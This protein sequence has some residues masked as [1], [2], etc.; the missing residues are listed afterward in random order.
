[1]NQL[2]AF[3]NKI[4]LAAGL[5]RRVVVENPLRTEPVSRIF[6]LDRGQPVDRF[7]IERFLAKYRNHI[8]GN[9]LEV[10]EDIY[11]R[12]FA[13]HDLNPVFHIL[14]LKETKGEG[15]N[16]GDLTGF[17]ILP[18]EA[19]GES[20]TLRTDSTGFSTSHHEATGE[21][22]TLHGDLTNAATLPEAVFDCFICT[23]T[24]NF[25]YEIEKAVA[26]TCRLLKPGGTLLA[27]VAGISQISAYDRDRWGDYWRLTPQSAKK[28]FGEVFGESNVE[29]TVCGNFAAARALLDGL[30]VEDLPDPE[31]L[32][33]HDADYPVIIGI[34]A[35]RET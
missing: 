8:K 32:N 22:E 5:Y 1:M 21:S 4:K 2:L 19:T 24:Y 3:L 11:S 17:S 35:Q 12:K 14:H 6:G 27:T 33:H 34:K 16:P 18:P 31:I 29:I 26:G 25:I 7:Y 30:A 23:Q 20:E 9:L 10:A 28:L 15:R 13:D